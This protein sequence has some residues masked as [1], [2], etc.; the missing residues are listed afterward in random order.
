MPAN[1]NG[2]ERHQMQNK[3]NDLTV[4]GIEFPRGNGVHIAGV[5]G[6]SPVSPT[7]NTK[8]NQYVR[9][10]A[11]QCAK[12]QLYHIKRMREV[13][14]YSP[15]EGVLYVKR[16]GKLAGFKNDGGYWRVRLNGADWPAHRIIWEWCH[17]VCLTADDE[18]DHIDGDRMNNRI[19][20][21]RK[22]TRAQNQWNAK[23]RKDNTS[24]FKGVSW[25]KRQK[26][27]AANISINGKVKFLGAF[28]TP[29][30]AHA[31]YT[32]RAKELRGEF[33]RVK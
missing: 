8:I 14:S 21:L 7:K 3:K 5:T 15:D 24:G 16:T 33:A 19:E 32:A 30:E 18:I 9:P 17:G 11:L 27:W 4:E 31:V 12:A 10:R 13:F 6:S 25:H 29:E 20:N 28:N 23:V 2:T 22:A 26:A 1:H